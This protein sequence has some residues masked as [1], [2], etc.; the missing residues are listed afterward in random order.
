MIDILETIDMRQY[1]QAELLHSLSVFL[2]DISQYWNKGKMISKYATTFIVK[3]GMT[4][5]KYKSII[6]LAYAC[7][8]LNYEAMTKLDKNIFTVLG[9]Q[10]IEHPEFEELLE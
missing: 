2:D 8:N 6:H 3:H 9:Q 7:S 5:F 1:T 10:L 4:E